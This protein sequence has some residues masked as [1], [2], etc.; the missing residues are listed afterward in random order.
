[1]NRDE[2]S[3]LTGPQLLDPGSRTVTIANIFVQDE[4]ALSANLALILGVKVEQNS[5]TKLEAMPSARL[6]WRSSNGHLLWAAV[7]R[8]VR[9]PSRVERD[10]A[11][12]GVVVPGFFQSEKLIAYEAGYRSVLLGRVSFSASIFY[13]DY[14]DLRTNDFDRPFSL[15]IRVGNTMVGET[16]GAEI[17]GAV[18][19]T[20]RWRVS[21]GATYLGK[22]FKLKPGSLDVAGFEAAG[23]DPD[24]WLKL[25]SQLQLT[26][27]LELDLR[28]RAVDDVPVPR[29][30][31]YRGADGFVDMDVRLAWRARPDLEFSIN[32]FNILHR[33]HEEASEARRSQ[34]P[35][36]LYVGVRWA[37]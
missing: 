2:F 8:A 17:W 32:A 25:R 37:S 24:G 33:Q 10:F 11:I 19:I 31:G 3:P 7:S 29:A 12:P 36:S 20:D 1:M 30:S 22:D 34:I 9:N 21:G 13:N 35:R 28:A 6:A 23:V 15:P 14:D 27:N 26:P 16:Y 18:D 5:Y 4:V